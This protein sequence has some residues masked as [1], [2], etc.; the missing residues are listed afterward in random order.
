M[1]SGWPLALGPGLAGAINRNAPTDGSAGPALAPPTVSS[2]RAALALSD[3]TL[4]IGFGSYYDGGIG[5][6]VAV[7]IR[8][9]R[10]SAAFSG[11]PAIPTPPPDD[12][13]NRASA[14]IWGAGGPAI[15]TDAQPGCSLV[16]AVRHRSA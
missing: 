10:V 13:E 6:M 16:C 1:L 7:D 11:A 3:G 9:R 14:G 12:P 5:W 8:A 2:Q 15:A 4:F